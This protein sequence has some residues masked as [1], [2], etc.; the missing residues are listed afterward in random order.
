MKF[1]AA[2]ALTILAAGLVL[3]GCA[4]VQSQWRSTVAENTIPGYQKF[5]D[6]HPNTE[7]TDSAKLA[8]EGLEYM[9]VEKENTRDA[10]EAFITENPRSRY[11]GNAK[12]RL[13]DIEFNDVVAA[14]TLAGYEGFIAKHPRSPKVPEARR[15]IDRLKAQMVTQEPAAAEEILS[16][17]PDAAKKGNIPDAYVG[18]WVVREKGIAGQ[19]LVITSSYVV[20]KVLSGPDAG[21][22]A[23]KPGSYQITPK[24]LKLKAQMAYTS[25]EDATG[26]LKMPVPL[27]IAHDGRT[28]KVATAPSDFRVKGK[29]ADLHDLLGVLPTQEQ[30]YVKL[31]RV[32]QTVVFVKA[33]M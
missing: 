4:S 10:Y 20:W 22:Q 26:K 27:T 32:P 15:S 12:N 29:L 7:Y 3:V 6:N 17:Y 5:A 31:T 18:N 8:I 19:Y 25:A 13:V 9:A 23:F 33:G 14:N 11:V 16:R 2:M 28:L 30:G 24:G 1:R 21:E